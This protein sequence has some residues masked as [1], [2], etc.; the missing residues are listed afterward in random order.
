MPV[1]ARTTASPTGRGDRVF[2][3]SAGSSWYAP[4]LAGAYALAAVA[5]RYGAE[6]LLLPVPERKT[7]VIGADGKL[8]RVFDD[9]SPATHAREV[10]DAPD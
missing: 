2:Y 6:R 5:R 9:V 1:D 4:Y 10:L 7:F 8:L 3:H